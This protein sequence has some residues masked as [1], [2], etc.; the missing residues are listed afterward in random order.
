MGY[1]LDSGDPKMQYAP[2]WRISFAT[3]SSSRYASPAKRPVPS[4]LSALRWL[5]AFPMSEKRA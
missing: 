3:W 2:S 4:Y 1:P 5:G